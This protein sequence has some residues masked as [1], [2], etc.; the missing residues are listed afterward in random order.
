MS[1]SCESDS[2]LRKDAYNYKWTKVKNILPVEPPKKD[3]TDD[4]ADASAKTDI[5]NVN[6]DT[7]Y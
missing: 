4:K 7:K 1:D 2:N 3:N 5:G 6:A